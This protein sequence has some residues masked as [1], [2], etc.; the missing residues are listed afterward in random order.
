MKC[1]K[2]NK[3][4]LHH[5]QVGSGAGQQ[6]VCGNADCFTWFNCKS[7]KVKEDERVT[8]VM[9]KQFPDAD[10]RQQMADEYPIFH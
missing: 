4:D 7:D 10:M 1:P 9:K 6:A 5:V 8:A 2:C 3:G